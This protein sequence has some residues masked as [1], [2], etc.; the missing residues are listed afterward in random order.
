MGKFHHQTARTLVE[1]APEG[2]PYRNASTEL[3]IRL[4]ELLYKHEATLQSESPGLE[5]DKILAQAYSRFSSRS[6]RL[7]G[8]TAG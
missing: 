6:W 3:R 8:G 2:T 5:Y 4:T 7:S 1:H